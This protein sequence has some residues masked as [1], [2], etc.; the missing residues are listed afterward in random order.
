M[1]QTQ[2]LQNEITELTNYLR[3][4]QSSVYDHLMENPI[5]LPD[6]NSDEFLE[7]LKEYKNYLENLIK[8]VKE[9]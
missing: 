5:T 4:E 6:E 1:N 3:E 2:E 8:Q 9:K 7:S